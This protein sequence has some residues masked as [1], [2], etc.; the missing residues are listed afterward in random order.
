MNYNPLAGDGLGAGG[1]D[2]SQPGTVGI[3]GVSGD[4]IVEILLCVWVDSR[5][6]SVALF[7]L[8][9]DWRISGGYI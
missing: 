5:P 9:L 1:G 8:H 3:K 7:Y 6:I 4:V 2:K